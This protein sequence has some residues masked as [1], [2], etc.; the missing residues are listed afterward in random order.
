L[1]EFEKLITGYA[2]LNDESTG[3]TDN[4]TT[5]QQYELKYSPMRCVLLNTGTR[6]V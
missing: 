6:T 3:K 5:L 4:N 1:D 2:V